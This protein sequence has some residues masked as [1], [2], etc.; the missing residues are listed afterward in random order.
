MVE[1]ASLA[2]SWFLV[3]VLLLIAAPLVHPAPSQPAPSPAA[4]LKASIFGRDSALTDH[5]CL[6]DSG[7][8]GVGE[9]A[10]GL[11][12]F[13]DGPLHVCE[14]DD[15]DANCVD[16]AVFKRAVR[17][18]QREAR[19]CLDRARRQHP[20]LRAQVLVEFR[21]ETDGSVRD[22]VSSSIV[23]EGDDEKSEALAALENCLERAVSRWKVAPEWL[24]SSSM[25]YWY[26]L[27]Y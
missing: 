17:N 14:N 10:I 20:L 13:S 5:P 18:Q 9:G 16:F 11:G 23:P 3:A 12:A 25:S 21:V 26:H 19:L 7:C 24:R 2:R 6:A 4:T 8:G 22:P 15:F 27:R 1:T